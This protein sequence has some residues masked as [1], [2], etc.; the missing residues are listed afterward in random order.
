MNE[1]QQRFHDF[2]LQ[3]V[4][5]GREEE[6]AAILR[7][8]FRKQDEGTFSPA[9]MAEIAPKMTTLLRPECIGEFQQAAAHMSSQIKS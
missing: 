4:Q 5:A 1:G 6:L 8:S 9:Y 7:E 2:A 3:R